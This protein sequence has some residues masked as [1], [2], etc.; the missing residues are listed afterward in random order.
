[1]NMKQR[2]KRLIAG[3]SAL[4]QL[5]KKPHP[6]LVPSGFSPMFPRTRWRVCFR[7]MRQVLMPSGEYSLLV[8]RLRNARRYIRFETGAALWELTQALA[9]TKRLYTLYA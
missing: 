1:M 2:W 7:R 4:C 9:Q 6:K 5:C 3:I 8:N